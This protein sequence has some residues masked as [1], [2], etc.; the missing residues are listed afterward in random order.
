MSEQQPPRR[1]TRK[2]LMRRNKKIAKRRQQRLTVIVVALTAFMVYIT[3]LFSTSIAYLGDFVSSAMVYLQFGDGFPVEIENQT[4]MQSEKMG[5]ALCVLDSQKLSFYSPTGDLA[6]S[7][8][9]SMQ[10]P[11]ISTSSKRVAIYNANDTSLKIAN[12]GS[13]LFSQEMSNDIIHASLADNNYVAVTTKSQSYN[14]E[15]KVF[16]AKMQEK[17]TWK[18]AKA[19]PLQSFLSSKANVLLV[20]CI[21]AKDGKAVSEV[22]IIDTATGEEKLVYN[23]GENIMLATEFVK[24]DSIIMFFTDKAVCVNFSEENE[25]TADISE[26]SYNGKNLLSYDIKNSQIVMALGDYDGME[27]TDIVITDLSIK[28]NFRTVCPQNVKRVIIASQRVYVLGEENVFQYTTEGVYVTQH[29][30][31]NNIRSIVE[32]N[33]CVAVYSDSMEKIEKVKAEKQS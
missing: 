9:H 17:F 15:V 22:Y 20:S 31:K 13:I 32:Y 3:G 18:S 19:F 1:L 10:N 30:V 29:E 26:Y 25:G 16:D 8:Y 24:E 23:N 21:S 7:Y 5:S 12:A 28:E 14:G 4:Y 27:G 33:G 11:V 2:E 6:H